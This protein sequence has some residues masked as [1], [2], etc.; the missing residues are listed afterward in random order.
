MGSKCAKCCVSIPQRRVETRKRLNLEILCHECAKEVEEYTVTRI[1]DELICTK[2]KE[3]KK[4][5][6]K[7]LKGSHAIQ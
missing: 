4:Y 2:S 1:D 6:Q 5:L 3:G 7:H